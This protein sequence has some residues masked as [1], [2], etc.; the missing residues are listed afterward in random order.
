M[1]FPMIIFFCD[2]NFLSVAGLNFVCLN[3]IRTFYSQ[4]FLFTIYLH[5]N[6]KIY[7]GLQYKY[8]IR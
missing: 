2:M 7:K 6:R 5:E 4:V 8:Q 1:Y 3:F